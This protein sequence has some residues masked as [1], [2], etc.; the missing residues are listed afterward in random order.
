[1][2]RQEKQS[3]VDS[4]AEA[5]RLAREVGS[6]DPAAEA[7]H[8]LA[9]LRAGYTF[10]ALAEVERLDGKEGEA[11]LAIAELWRELDD[12]DRAI[13]AAIRAHKWAV[14]DGSPIFTA[15]CTIAA[16]RRWKNLVPNSRKSRNTTPPPTHPSTGRRTSEK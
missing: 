15:I 12:R 13:A 9:R 1:M 14:A 3:A 5:V 11:A 10:D 7:Y 8:A 4:L 6:Q 16:G 2:Q